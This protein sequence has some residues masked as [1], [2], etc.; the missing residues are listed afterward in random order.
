MEGD[1]GECIHYGAT[2]SDIHDTTFVLQLRAAASIILNDMREIAMEAFEKDITLKE[3]LLMHPD[4]T[5][6]LSQE[7]LDDML[8]RTTYTGLSAQTVDRTIEQLKKL[9]QTDQL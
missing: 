9:R 4:V 2:T 1:A 8:D 7:E 5:R 6:H 3:A